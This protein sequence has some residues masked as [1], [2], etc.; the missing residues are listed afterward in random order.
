V[1]VRKEDPHKIR[2]SHSQ[3]IEMQTWW[4][5]KKTIGPNI[6]TTLMKKNINVTYSSLSSFLFFAVHSL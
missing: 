3:D 4:M 6:L 1:E 2:S 5:K